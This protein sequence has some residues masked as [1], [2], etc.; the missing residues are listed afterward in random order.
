MRQRRDNIVTFKVGSHRLVEFGLCPVIIGDRGDLADFGS[1]QRVLND[2]QAEGVGE[3]FL[4]TPVFL[5]EG[6]LREFRTLPGYLQTLVPQFAAKMP[7][8]LSSTMPSPLTSPGTGI[9]I[10]G[11]T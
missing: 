8:S 3:A 4:E 11:P 10:G 2:E 7:A 6:G 1:D 9:E 5:V